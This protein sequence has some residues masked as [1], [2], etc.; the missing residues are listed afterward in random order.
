MLTR[1]GWG[2]F[3]NN[4]AL[5][6][7]FRRRMDRV[8]EEFDEERS[9]PLYEGGTTGWPRT[10]LLDTGSSLVLRAEVPGLSEKDVTLMIN[11]DVLTLSGERRAE[12]PEGYSVHRRERPSAKFARSIA[13]PAKVDLEKCQAVVKNGVLT[14]T[15]PKAPESQPR[16][17]SVRAQ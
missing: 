14:V 4:F 5:M 8:F 16:Q 13:L 7:E 3:N 9:L 2:D 10:S 15:L 1:W 11:Q 6:D 17:I 12:A